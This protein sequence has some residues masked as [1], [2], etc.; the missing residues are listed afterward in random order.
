[1]RDKET[2]SRCAYVYRER[3]ERGITALRCGYMAERDETAEKEYHIAPQHFYGRVTQRFPRGRET[4][5]KDEP[6]PA[7]CR[8]R[9]KKMQEL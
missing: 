3:Q 1:M 9:W 5:V 2:C 6:P 4:L 7:W 8:G